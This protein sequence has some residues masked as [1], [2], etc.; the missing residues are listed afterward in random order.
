M[1]EIIHSD[2]KWGAL[3]VGSFTGF[4]GVGLIDLL[5]LVLETLGS[6]YASFSYIGLLALYYTLIGLPIAFIL[7]LTLGTPLYLLIQMTGPIVRSKA[8]LLGAVMGALLGGLNFLLI[9]QGLLS[10]FWGLDILSTIAVGAFAGYVSFQK[11][12][13]PLSDDT[14][15]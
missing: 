15:T 9:G 11:A 7:C 14:F 10:L 13:E 8:I 3:V 1:T 6:G 2:N 4:V 5:T 12:K